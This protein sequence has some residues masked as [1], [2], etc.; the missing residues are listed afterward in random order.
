MR[1]NICDRYVM[2]AFAG[3]AALA[4]VWHRIV[5]QG[6][7]L[8]QVSNVPFSA[9]EWLALFALFV[10]IARMENDTLFTRVEL[11]IIAALGVAFALPSMKVACVAM[12]AAALMFVTSRDARLSSAGQL[13]LAL[14]SFQYFARLIFDLM[15][16]YAL[17]LETVA[18]A[19]LLSPFGHFRRD[20]F[21][22]VGPNGLTIFIEP[23]C[24]AFHNI[25]VAVIIWLGLIKIERLHFTR[26]D[27]WALAAMI[28][29]TILVNTIRITLMAQSL[30]MLQYWHD[31]AGVTIVTVVM[32]FSVL[33]IS[34]LSRARSGSEARM[35]AI[36]LTRA[37]ALAAL[38]AAALA[39]FLTR[40]E[41]L[42]AEPPRALSSLDALLGLQLHD[43]AVVDQV[44]TQPT[45]GVRLRLAEC[46]EPAFL[47][48]VPIEWVSTA[49]T[50]TRAFASQDH[51][52]I[53]VYRGKFDV[54]GVP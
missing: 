5:L 30:T 37:F 27:W 54:T 21:D 18:V 34:L 25:S 17:W 41:S 13:L 3:C 23:P 33:A 12:T 31:G 20:G 35:R 16:P 46:R 45:D 50:L 14:V 9:A 52:M 28:F 39:G 44:L 15:A 43:G 26:S 4:T 42:K 29:A 10:V 38:V 2:F 48:P 19:T 36:E 47:F 32:L 22:I 24:S 11:L 40:W 53:D 7:V 49:E 51:K 8:G 1:V 6:V